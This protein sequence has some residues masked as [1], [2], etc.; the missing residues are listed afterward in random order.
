MEFNLQSRRFCLQRAAESVLDI[1]VV[2]GGI[3]GAGV[4]REAALAGFSTALV[5][6]G[7]FASGTSS[8]S[9]KLIHG[10]VRYLQQ[11]DIG[12]VREAARERG[13][14]HR[15]APHLARPVSM[16]IPTASRGGLLKVAAG[17]WTFDR[18]AGD[19]SDRHRV[20]SRV[21]TRK[22]E[23]RL[24]RADRLSGS[25]VFTE[26]LT[27]DA[28]LVLETIQSAVAEGAMAANYSCVQSIESDPQGLRVSLRDCVG[29]EDL[30]VRCRCLVNAGGPWME[31]VRT[32]ASEQ[33]RGLLQLTRGIHLVVKRERL[34]V[35]HIV[36]LRAPDG[37]STFVVPAGRYAYL[38]TTDT[39]YHGGR[40]EP[41]VSSMDADYLLESAASTF[42]DAPSADDIVGTWSGVRPL[43]AQA[44]KAPSEISRRDEILEGPGP[45]VSI[46][47]GKLTTYR[48]MAERVLEHVSRMIGCPPRSRGDSSERPLAGGGVREQT[49][50]RRDAPALEDP[51]LVDRLWATYGAA[52]CGIA[53]RIAEQPSAGEPLGGLEELTTAEVEH[54]V[55]AEMVVTLDDM[56]RRRSRVAM[57]DGV[58]ACDA[59]ADVAA[60]MGRLLGWNRER[61]REEAESFR[62]FVGS[63]LSAVRGTE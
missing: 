35:K 48:R 27:N 42:D 49:Q 19:P 11:G 50:A 15:M 24:R 14:L 29:G 25:V 33:Q 62:G 8:R 12:L 21:Q 26:Y 32:L 20:L 28:R 52:A 40:E 7:D 45:M 22:A 4:A 59:A 10:G 39:H 13:R 18:L 37:R 1:L 46:A 43:L 63:E 58:A 17:L 51:A 61:E 3:T 55:Q 60:C 53:R 16:M 47:G 6:K 57:F 44:G 34:P 41:G 56:L 36:V 38:G 5:D 54:A 31:A 2:G 30:V 9:S 23:P